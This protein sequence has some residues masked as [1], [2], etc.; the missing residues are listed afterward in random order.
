MPGIIGFQETWLVG[1]RL[2]FKRNDEGTTEYP[3]LDL[4]TI[5]Q[6]TPTFEPTVI[7]AKDPDGGRLNLI[8]EAF[9]EI[10]EAYEVTCLNINQENLDILYY[11]N[12]TQELQPNTLDG[13][14]LVPHTVKIGPGKLVKVFEGGSPK[15]GE[16]E[17]K[18]AYN[19]S[20][21]QI[22]KGSSG[23]TTLVAFNGTNA[24]TADFEVVSAER[25]LIR[26]FSTGT[27][28]LADGDTCRISFNENAY[29]AGNTRLVRP[30]QASGPI[31]GRAYIVFSRNNNTR[32]SVRECEATI[33]VSSVAFGIEDYSSVT[34][35]VSVLTDIH[36]TN[37]AGRYML[38]EGNEI[39]NDT[40]GRS[41]YLSPSTTDLGGSL[42]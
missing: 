22:R 11:G 40:P 9:T 8:D 41:L 23:P 37:I 24:S 14:T 16:T 13:N 10:N 28:S 4:G 6:T 7:Q 25:G 27:N 15:A 20:V 12:G 29:A 3:T 30:Q 32:Q 1:S 38:I 33:N 36:N 17:L 21:T 31:T 39:E 34:F 18:A 42:P 5:T 19:I 2:Y 26:F 35:N